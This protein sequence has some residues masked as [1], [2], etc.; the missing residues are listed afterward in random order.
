VTPKLKLPGGPDK[1]AT[2]VWLE[3]GELKVE[4]YD[5]S[6]TAH[7]LFGNDIAHTITVS[8]MKKLY[9]TIN[10]DET[11]LVPWMAQYFKSYF[12]IK[13]WLEENRIE[14]RIERESW[15]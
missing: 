15:A 2:W 13:E 6:E 5:F 11:T 14:F 7:T 1:S 3:A 12:E 8:E 10:K 4:I 9:S